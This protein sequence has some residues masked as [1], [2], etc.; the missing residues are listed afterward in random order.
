MRTVSDPGPERC[1]RVGGHWSLVHTGPE[2]QPLHFDI[3]AARDKPPAPLIRVVIRLLPCAQNP[4]H[5]LVFAHEGFSRMIS[6]LMVANDCPLDLFDDPL[7]VFEWSFRPRSGR[8][9]LPPRKAPASAFAATTMT[10]RHIL[11]A[12]G[13]ETPPACGH[14]CRSFDPQPGLQASSA[15]RAAVNPISDSS[16]LTGR[17]SCVGRKPTKTARSRIRRAMA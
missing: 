16:R 6:F 3:T 11:S 13:P 8:P 2:Y 10:A 7:P 17:A 1:R 4:A 15:R 9:A 5:G 12:P 14:A